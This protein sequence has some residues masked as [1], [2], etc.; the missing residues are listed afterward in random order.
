MPGDICVIVV[1]LANS[2]GLIAIIPAVALP[3]GAF[4]AAPLIMFWYA[5]FSAV[6]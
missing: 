2:C 1:S 4:I 3:P 6:F 5:E